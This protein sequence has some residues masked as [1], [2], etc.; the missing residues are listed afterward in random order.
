MECDI[1]DYKRSRYDEIG[2][3]TMNTRVKVSRKKDSID[4][5]IPALPIS[6]RMG[7]DL[8]KES[9]Y[10]DRWKGTDAEEDKETLH[11]ETFNEAGY[12]LRLPPVGAGRHGDPRG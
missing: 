2:T 3:E 11:D 8:P 9:D 5:T 4:K 6:G 12:I 10:T 1:A 7:N